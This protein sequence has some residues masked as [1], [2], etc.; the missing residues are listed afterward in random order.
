[1]LRLVKEKGVKTFKAEA[2]RA[3]KSFPVLSPILRGR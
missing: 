1:M 3:D 2:K